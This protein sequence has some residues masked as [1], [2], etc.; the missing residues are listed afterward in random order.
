M[1]VRSRRPPDARIAG[2]S[3]APPGG[4]TCSPRRRPFRFGEA[5]A[6]DPR[7]I[8]E[9]LRG[10]VDR[11]PDAI[12]ILAPGRAPLTYQALVR[13]IDH[14]REMLNVR[15]VGREDRVAL[16]L[17]NGAD[18]GVAVLCISDAATCAPLNPA[19]TESE[20]EGYF[21]SLDASVLIAEAAV[22]TPARAAA[23]RL[24]IAVIDL[25]LGDDGP[26]GV[27]DLR[28]GGSGPPARPGRAEW[29]DIAL[30]LQT[31]GTTL[32]PKIVPL[33]HLNLTDRAY[34]KGRCVALGP[35]DRCLHFMPLFHGQGINM[36]LIPPL[37]VGGG[38]VFS[39]GFEVDLFFRLLAEFRPTWYTAGPTH[40]REILS[41]AGHYENVIRRCPLR[42]IRSSSGHLSPKVMME[43]ER[44]FRAPVIESYNTSEAGTLACAPFAPAARRPGTVGLAVPG[45]VAIMDEAGRLLGAEE[46]GEI[47]TCGASVF[48]G[49]EDNAK[50][51]ATAFTD[52]W[53]R[54]GD[55]GSIDA[56]GYLTLKGRI[57]EIINRGGEKVAPVEVDLAL[58]AH[59]A[60]VEAMTF[61]MPHRTLNE[62]VGAAVVLECGLRVTEDEL[63]RFARERLALFKVPRRIVVV[64]ALPKGPTGKPQRF[65]LADKLGLGDAAEAERRR[66]PRKAQSART[67]V[68]AELAAIWAVELGL[69]EVGL[70]EDFF[71]LGGDSLQAIRMFLRIEERL[72]KTLSRSI[73]FEAATVEE[74]A[75]L[76]EE[77]RPSSCLVPINTE[78]RH[79]PFFCV[80]DGYGH[81]LNLRHLAR[82]LGPEQPFYGLQ[83]RGLDGRED[84]FTKLEDMAAHYIDEIRRV[85]PHGPYYIGGYSFGGK[86]A[87]EMAQQLRA[88]G[89]E[90]GL[91]ALLDSH[92]RG[93][94]QTVPVSVWLKRHA[95]RMSG[96]ALREKVR[97]LGVRARNMGHLIGRVLR[98]PVFWMA[99][100][101][102]RMSGRR[103]SP[104]FLHDTNV[105][106]S[107][108][109]RPKV[110]EGRTVLF[111]AELYAWAHPDVHES[112]NELVK[113]GVE[114]R[115][116][117]GQHFNLIEEPHVQG[118]AKELQE[119]LH[120]AQAQKATTPRSQTLQLR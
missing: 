10:L 110:F 81:V 36:G 73:L 104:R 54:T 71:L 117:P 52:G 47:V 13:Q 3:A 15:G 9:T 46:T 98:R 41:R 53:F 59:P 111:C 96:L 58:L 116:V 82:R 76:I 105:R 72:G 42:F 114:M 21:S 2:S 86:V 1:R 101:W 25:V 50:T 51:N 28:G 88:H 37:L 24:G 5:T 60:V 75:R 92:R 106:A 31:A 18:M 120:E 17:A 63:R 38:V 119:C 97:Y 7:T 100:C 69:E 35:D 44:T 27:F 33:N 20:F 55:L 103:L 61:A 26:A 112:W 43:L 109:Y 6:E 57:K 80:H 90:V 66:A 64:D 34:K 108:N 70:D 83:T 78:G 99:F 56:D 4:R 115:R 30:I 40:H 77:T 87:F 12:A 14:V 91:L 93:V 89:E 85:Q 49:Y 118:L 102:H 113:G 79:P 62:E 107:R 48:D 8:G 68:E 39:P 23:E 94:R 22:E 19:Y 65:G 95:E 74:M 29:T 67:P 11:A 84:L 45:D 32:G 16:V